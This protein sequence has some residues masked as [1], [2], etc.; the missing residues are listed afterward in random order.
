[1]SFRHYQT[2]KDS[3]VTWLGKVPEYWEV[4]RLKILASFND[5]V[6]PESTDPDME[7]EYVDISSVSVDNGIEKTESMRF[8]NAPSRARRLVHDGDIIVST[9]RTY[10]KA[11]APIKNPPQNLVVS[12]G[13]AVIRPLSDFEPVFA[14]YALQ[15][16]YFMDEVISRSTGVSYPAINASDMATIQLVVPPRLEQSIIS[17]FLDIETGKIDAL[18]SEQRTLINLLK[19]ERQALISYAVTKGLNPDVPMKD[20]GLEWLGEVPEHWKVKKLKHLADVRLSNIDKHTI[21]GQ[22]AV[23]LCNYVDVY[24]NERITSAID[25]MQATASDE[26]IERLTV[27]SR[28][29]LITKDSEDPSDIG[30]PALIAEDIPGLVCGYHLAIIR[31]MKSAGDFL[32]YLFRSNFVCSVFEA[33]ATGMTR[34]ALGKYSIE[35]LTFAVPPILE[36]QAIAAFLDIKTVKIDTLISEAGTAI[37]LLQERRTALISAAVTGKIDVRETN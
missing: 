23:S 33:E 6:L 12:T 5:D 19:E 10:L 36:Q 14:H 3:G 25:F 11:I 9:V 37:V 18:I 20:S 29:V 17:S 15:S 31:P 22:Q 13:F 30:V 1:M 7:I 24:K 26:Q 35:N 8:E 4:R 27:Y 16:E 2:D 34:Y 28:D 32:Q 21:E